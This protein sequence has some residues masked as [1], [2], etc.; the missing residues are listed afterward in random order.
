MSVPEYLPGFAE[1][2]H[3]IASDDVLSIYRRFETLNARNNLY[4]QAELQSLEFKLN[5]LDEEDASFIRIGAPGSEKD[6]IEEAARVWESFSAQVDAGVDRQVKRMNLVIRIR[7]VMKEYEKS[8]LRRSQIL[9]LPTPSSQSLDAFTSFFRTKTPFFGP[10]YELLSSSGSLVSL[11]QQTEG[12][13]R[14]STFIERYFG[15]YLAIPDTT[16]PKSWEPLYYFPARRVARV[17]AF[18]S[19]LICALLMMGAILTLYYIPSTQMGKRLAAVGAFTT[20]FATAVVLL[21]NAKRGEIL[22]VSAA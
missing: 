19:V 5:R 22:G 4:L 15:Y 20:A 8:L 18:L 2:S 16:R 7:E 11:K 17:V 13:D 21:T 10:S 6:N 3:F 12:P 9:S 14:L 1:F